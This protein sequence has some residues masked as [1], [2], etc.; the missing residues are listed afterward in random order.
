M[1]RSASAT[2]RSRDEFKG[3]V[4]DGSWPSSVVMVAPPPMVLLP[5]LVLIVMAIYNNNSAAQCNGER[6]PVSSI[7]LS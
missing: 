4:L 7:E 3:A 5:V 6:D 1:G 2:R